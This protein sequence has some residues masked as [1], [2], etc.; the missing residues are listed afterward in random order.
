MA[1]ESSTPPP[2][3]CIPFNIIAVF[4]QL[5]NGCCT[6]KVEGDTV[7]ELIREAGWNGDVQFDE[8]VED[9]EW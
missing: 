7:L 8:F 9:Y 2:F 1:V 3:S 6:T 5:S 4:V